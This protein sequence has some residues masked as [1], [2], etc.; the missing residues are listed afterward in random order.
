MEGGCVLTAGGQL[1]YHTLLFPSNFRGWRLG[2]VFQSRRKAAGGWEKEGSL[3]LM[4][5]VLA[6]RSEQREK[7]LIAGLSA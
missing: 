4:A 2:I 1:Y 7:T 5:H 6:Q 3:L